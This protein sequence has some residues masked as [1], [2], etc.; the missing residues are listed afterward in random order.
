MLSCASCRQRKLKC[1]RNQPC[2]NCVARSTDCVYSSASRNR[3]V[4]AQRRDGNANLENRLRR[5]EE[6]LN[7]MAPRGS[8]QG[9]NGSAATSSREQNDREKGAS[10]E[11]NSSL[12]SDP[13]NLSDVKPGRMMSSDSQVAYVSST[14]W[15]ALCNEV[16]ELREGLE[17]TNLAE[18]TDNA[19]ISYGS[20]PMLLD[21]LQRPPDLKD[22]LSGIP[23]REVTNRL[24]SRYFTSN[25]ISLVILHAPTFEKE[26]NRF[27]QDQEQVLPAWLAVLYGV[28]AMGSFLF[29][30][31][32][33]D[34]PGDL[35]N[36]LIA[37]E[38]FQ[39]RSTECLMLSNY[40]SSPGP[41]TME[42][43]AMNTQ[44]EFVRRRDASVGVWVLMGVAIRLALRMGYHRDP[45]HYPQLSAFQGEMR[46]RVWALT[47]QLDAL[48]SC[49][50][51]LPPMINQ[52]Q[53]D[54]QQP[55]N[56]LDEDFGPDFARLPPSRPETEL[57]PVL[58]T[59]TKTR[60]T[61]VFR[62][63]FNHAGLGRVDSY[64]QI[65]ELDQ[66][67]NTTMQS[68]SPRLKLTSFED[69]VSVPPWL[70]IHRYSLE[71]LSLK[72]RCILHRYY[73][74]QAYS[75]P[76]Y[77]YS[78]VSCV[79]A[80]MS[81]LKYH[82][83][84]LAET[85][86]GGLLCQHKW[87][88]SSLELHDFLLSAMVVCLELSFRARAKSGSGG[89]QSPVKFTREELVGSLQRSQILLDTLKV[90][91][92]DARKASVALAV[93]VKNFTQPQKPQEESVSG[94]EP[95]DQYANSGSLPLYPSEAESI[96]GSMSFDE[97]YM[98][99]EAIQTSHPA[100]SSSLEG[101]GTFFNTSEIIDW[102]QWEAFVQG[103]RSTTDSF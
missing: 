45:S 69:S 79:E 19:E 1:D 61:N 23:P 28:L 90:H 66:R 22:I 40:S 31:S 52:A 34:L 65:M 63:I 32:Q 57:T 56:L 53:C 75:D 72:A 71:L 74:T 94:F 11:D 21:G 26:Y 95:R 15:A 83:Q 35:G 2:G 6:L 18:H 93:M 9:S 103:S 47:L 100:F 101:V 58:Y 96:L 39:R 46:R 3:P 60:M 10:P 77:N 17:Q 70:L 12:Q 85:Q 7:T 102:D 78:R 50:I 13:S 55:R 49:Q 30:R 8:Q 48:T 16:A 98:S 25:V 37:I 20:G 84:I 99:S 14:H 59:I 24:V 44:I 64:N 86:D 43:L 5:L 81:I 80:A 87:F 33:E 68:I 41:Y 73:M 4:A 54:T 51:G 97:P 92:S 76:K 67:L 88:L 82:G 42:A 27:W 36:T 89:G 29:L 38:A 91:S 62:T